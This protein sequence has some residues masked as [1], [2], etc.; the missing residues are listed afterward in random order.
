MALAERLVDQVAALA[1]CQLQS[2]DL[3]QREILP[4]AIEQN[5]IAKAID[6]GESEHRRV[7]AFGAAEISH[8]D[9]EMIESFDFHGQ[10][11][12]PARV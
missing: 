6:H 11:F 1:L 5:L 9:S 8:F 3:E 2:R 12:T 4:A 10:L 7:E